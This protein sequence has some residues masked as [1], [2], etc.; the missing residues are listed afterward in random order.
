MSFPSLVLTIAL[1][2]G[3]VFCLAFCIPSNF[4]WKLDMLF[5]TEDTEVNIFYT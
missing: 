3:N 1:S 4:G 2:V 5:K